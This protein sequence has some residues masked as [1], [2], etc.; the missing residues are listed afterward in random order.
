M[1]PLLT[2]RVLEVS[3]RPEIDL[4]SPGTEENRYGFEGGRTIVHNGD[5]HLFTAERFA[6]PLVV[7]MRLGHW[8][9]ANGSAWERVST[10][11]ESSGEFTGADPRAALWGPM[12]IFDEAENVWMLFYV[13]YRAKPNTPE[14][15]YENYEGRIWRAVSTVPGRGGLGGPYEDAGVI[16]EPG[17]E[18][19]SWEGLQGVDSFHAHQAADGRWI[20]FYGS[21]QTQF[22]PCRF[23][24]VGLAD[25]AALKGP[26]RRRPAGNPV[27]MDD[28]FAENPVV[29]R[30]GD[31]WVAMVDGGPKR[32]AFGYATSEDGETWSRAAWIDLCEVLPQPWWKTMR[33]PLGLVP[34]GDG[35]FRIYFTALRPLPEN[36]L[37]FGALG[38]ARVEF[39]RC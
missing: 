6:D 31:L 10:L 36:G 24:G 11:Y 26:W 33:T 23:W 19:Q 20:G 7:K 3:A 12:P 39:Q 37:D 17:P 21:A 4:G 13:A 28:V 22:M 14:A 16:L 38:C 32:N 18:S 30:L 25:A 2:H 35:T 34:H 29:D 27:K 5:V 8:R 15:W 1:N 9:Q